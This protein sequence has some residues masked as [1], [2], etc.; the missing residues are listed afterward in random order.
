M[1]YH[2]ELEEIEMNRFLSF[3]VFAVFCGL[4]LIAGYGSYGP[5]MPTK[6]EKATPKGYEGKEVVLVGWLSGANCFVMGHSCTPDHIWKYHEAIG[7]GTADN[8]FYFLASVPRDTLVA[9]FTKKATV[10]GT[11]Y[12]GA[13]VI[14]V[15]GLKVSSGGGWDLVYGSDFTETPKEPT[16]PPKPVTAKGEIKGFQGH[17]MGVD[18]VLKKMTCSPDHIWKKGEYTGF[19]TNDDRF[20]NLIGLPENFLAA[21]FTKPFYVHGIYYETYHTLLVHHIAA[22]E[23]GKPIWAND[24]VLKMAH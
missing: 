1:V 10:K 16:A 8:K 2:R 20:I 13:N 24:E 7:F 4:L 6:R 22:D 14:E 18:C 11:A 15:S 5:S 3:T 17:I 9:G 19:A 21:N 23:K 12:D